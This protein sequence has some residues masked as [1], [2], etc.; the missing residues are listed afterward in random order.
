[1][2]ARFVAK[3]WR[4][5]CADAK[6]VSGKKD[7]ACIAGVGCNRGARVRPTS[8]IVPAP[9]VNRAAVI[10]QSWWS[11][12]TVPSR[13]RRRL[14]WR[15]RSQACHAART[16]LAGRTSLG[17]ITDICL[18]SPLHHVSRE[19][20]TAKRKGQPV[21]HG[22]GGGKVRRG[23]GVAPRFCCLVDRAFMPPPHHP[24]RWP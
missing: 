2:P 14:T 20:T 4:H 8:T 17:T 6:H 1:M 24:L 13:R 16:L 7:E 21:P 3:A 19:G 23:H 18:P 15:A 22:P 12:A 10:A 11:L 5:R 9:T